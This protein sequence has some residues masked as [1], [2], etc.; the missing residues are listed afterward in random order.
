M[1]DRE[2]IQSILKNELPDASLDL[3]S[4]LSAKVEQEMESHGRAVIRDLLAQGLAP[5]CAP[6][7]IDIRV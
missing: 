4:K 2:D 7:N 6:F 3:V 5:K 1:L